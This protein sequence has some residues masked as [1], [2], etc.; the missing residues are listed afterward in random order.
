MV[1]I[2]ASKCPALQ[3]QSVVEIIHGM[4]VFSFPRDSQE[5]TAVRDKITF[6]LL[7]N[8]SLSLQ[9]AGEKDVSY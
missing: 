4:A 9:G 6:L 8:I 2:K 1:V 7:L 3:L 5:K